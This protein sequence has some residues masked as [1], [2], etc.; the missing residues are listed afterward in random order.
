M[1]NLLVLGNLFLD[2]LML[3]LQYEEIDRT[4]V[5][6]IKTHN[7]GVKAA[8]RLRLISAL[9][10]D[11][12][13]TARHHR[14]H[15]PTSLIFLLMPTFSRSQTTVRNFSSHFSNLLAALAV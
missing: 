11:F 15:F 2:T 13:I 14:Y 6:I 5:I 8:S 4:Q 10:R 3:K 7:Q 12:E 9:F 1:T